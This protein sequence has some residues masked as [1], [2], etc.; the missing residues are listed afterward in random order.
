M[1]P[2][3]LP[4]IGYTF[5]DHQHSAVIERHGGLAELTYLPVLKKNGAQMPN[6]MGFPIFGQGW[7]G[8]GEELY[9]PVMRFISVQGGGENLMH[10]PLKDAEIFPFGC[11]GLSEY[12]E[13]K[14]GYSFAIHEGVLA[15]RLTNKSPKRKDLKVIIH[16]QGLF[17]GT[18]NVIR[19]QTEV[20]WSVNANPPLIE[21]S[22]G[23]KSFSFNQ[24]KGVLGATGKLVSPEGVEP[25]CLM[26]AA[27]VPLEADILTGPIVLSASWKKSRRPVRDVFLIWDKSEKKCLARLDEL[28][29]GSDVIMKRQLKR[30]AAI[31]RSIPRFTT[32]AR[33]LVDSLTRQMPAQM[34]SL[35]VTESTKY[36][37]VRAASRSYGVF[38]NWDILQPARGFAAWGQYERAKKALEFCLGPGSLAQPFDFSLAVVTLHDIHSFTGDDDYLKSGYRKLRGRFHTCADECGPEGMEPVDGGLGVDTPAELG[39]Y[40]KVLTPCICG[41]WY[42]ACRLM[43]NTATWV[44]DKTTAERAFMLALAIE[45]N[46]LKCFYDP[47]VKALS[48][49]CNPE[50][51]KRNSSFQNVATFGLEGAFG[52][53]L[54][55]PVEKDL[56]RFLTHTLKHTQHRSAVPYWDKARE[57]WK[58]CIM[59]FHANHECRI[60]RRA[61][62]TEELVRSIDFYLDLFEKHGIA[63]ETVNLTPCPNNIGQDMKTQSMSIYIFWK[64]ML[65]GILGLMV[66]RGGITYERGDFPEDARVTQWK[67]AGSVWDIEVKGRGGWVKRMTLDGKAIEGTF[68]VPAVSRG[69]HKL[70]IVRGKKAPQFGTILTAIDGKVISTMPGRGCNRALLSGAG[71]ITVEFYAESRPQ[72]FW[73]GEPVEVKWNKAGLTAR[74]DCYANGEGELLLERV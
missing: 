14:L 64:V 66:D 47:D 23:W 51:K 5:S 72:A 57:M 41:L 36:E 16:P 10:A 52:H 50:T 34:E 31:D 35:V 13:T 43:E 62:A 60:L 69:S 32:K 39:I 44:G 33:P 29:S 53:L 1:E 55:S 56:A 2:D 67:V 70:V 26:V 46:Y 28:R 30:Y 4:G 49:A 7:T 15:W 68:K 17:S 48:V 27:D 54:T 63:M 59:L 22:L 11:T 42:S 61:G 74:I 12:G 19:E 9:S 24:K 6:Q 20:F 65:N 21:E 58:N 8:Q 37:T 40:K 38:W 45:E 18:V 71:R 3:G 73:R 25:I